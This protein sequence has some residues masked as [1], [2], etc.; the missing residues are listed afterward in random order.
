MFTGI[1]EE[2]GTIADVRRIENGYAL[3]IQGQK[4]L[5]GTQLGDSIAVN[6]TCLTVTEFDHQS[7]A[8]GVAPETRNRTNLLSLEPGS[9]VNLER[10]V[11][12]STRLGGHYVQGHVD[13]TGKITAFRPDRESLWVT[14]EASPEIMKYIVPKGF[15]CLDGT[16]LTVVDCFPNAFTVMLVAYTQGHIILPEKKIGYLVNIE[17]DILGKYVEK[18]IS[19][20]LGQVSA[21]LDQ[22]FLKKHGFTPS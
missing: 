17:V 5:E 20:Q 11:T 13:G 4:V 12:P 9:R 14:I 2:I 10:A 1:V 19:A 22:D 7:F 8:V 6:G 16:S 18:L 15:I 21:N 3:R